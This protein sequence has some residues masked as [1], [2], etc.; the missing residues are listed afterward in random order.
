MNKSVFSFFLLSILFFAAHGN[1]LQWDVQDINFF[2]N[3]TFESDKLIQ[4]MQL[5]PKGIL[6]RTQFSITQ[7]QKDINSLNTFYRNRGFFQAEITS[8]LDFDSSKKRVSIYLFIDEGIRTEIDSVEFVGNI[9]YNDSTLSELIRIKRGS[10]LDSSLYTGAQ[11]EILEFYGSLGR[12]FARVEYFFEFDSSGKTA[13]LIITVNEG[14]VVRTGEADILGLT[15]TDEKVVK[16]ELQ[17]DPYEIINSQKI[18]SSVNNLYATGLFKLVNIMP[19]DIQAYPSESDTIIAPVLIQLDEADFF[20]IRLGAGYNS[21]D[22]WYGNV[23]L[24]YKNLFGLGHRIYL[25]SRL[26]SVVLQAQAGYN[27]PWLFNRDFSGEMNA[28]IE[29]RALESFKA[30]YQGG[31]LAVNGN[32]GIQNRYRVVLNYKHTGWFQS[33]LQSPEKSNTLLLGSRFTRDTRESYLDPGNAFFSY[34]EAEIAGPALSFSNQFYRIKWD[35]RLY[36]ELFIKQLNLSSAFFWGYVN[37]FGRSRRVPPS[38]LLRIG[39]DEIRPV[40]GFS[41]NQVSPVNRENEAIG[42]ELAAV[43]NLFDLRFP[44]F[45]VI[46]GEL[47]ID[48]GYVWSNPRDFSLKDLKWSAGPGLLVTLPSGIF[49]IDYGFELRKS[50]DFRGGWYFGLGHAF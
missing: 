23:E 32:I 39:I 21:F 9:L 45:T 48:G 5:K 14:P 34:I 35:V 20:D 30:L 8:D 50:F 13:D 37:N 28:Y 15:K 12:I 2:G 10:I 19:I 25:S 49:R 11:A 26:S 33:E 4:Q 40:R 22:K 7:L 17:F 38:E 24:A 43:I 6:S 36:R 29:R 31:L 46:S 18:R 44:L 27:Y 1:D 3:N 47:F 42:G 41:E 16:R